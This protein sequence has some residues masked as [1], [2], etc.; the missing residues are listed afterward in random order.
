MQKIEVVTEIL[1]YSVEE[2]IRLNTIYHTLLAQCKAAAEKA[3]APYS[4]FRVGAAT[5]LQN[6]KIITGSNQENVAFPAG[7][8]AEHTAIS[9][10]NAT[11]PDTPVVAIAICA[12]KDNKPTEMP[13]NP[14]G[15]CRQVLL[16]TENR[17]H[18]PIQIILYGNK[19]IRVAKSAKSLL[20]LSFE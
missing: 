15:T 17:F 2:F 16:E 3:Y 8:C 7:I 4:H 5:L 12:L 19:L 18:L 9:C 14:C 13:V 10:A 11:Y 6:N 20:P 1:E